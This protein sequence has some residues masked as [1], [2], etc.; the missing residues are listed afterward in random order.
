MNA[1]EYANER[2]NVIV[3]IAGVGCPAGLDIALNDET[4]L[5]FNLEDVIG[6]VDLADGDFTAELPKR[7]KDWNANT[8][9]GI[10]LRV[11]PEAWAAEHAEWMAS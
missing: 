10:W 9:Y 11:D 3:R 6:E 1:L 8:I 7:C 5:P 2:K 4:E